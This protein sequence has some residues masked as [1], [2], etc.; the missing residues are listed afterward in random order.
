MNAAAAALEDA[1]KG[2]IAR[3]GMLVELKDALAVAE[4]SPTSKKASSASLPSPSE[5]GTAVGATKAKR[6]GM[7]RLFG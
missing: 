1:E 7:G 2:H 3:K 5:E 6:T 4:P